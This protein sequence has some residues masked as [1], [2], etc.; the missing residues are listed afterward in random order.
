[1]KKSSGQRISG[2]SGE[3]VIVSRKSNAMKMEVQQAM[4]KRKVEEMAEFCRNEGVGNEY[5][6]LTM[7]T[8]FA[9]SKK[10]G[11][12]PQKLHGELMRMADEKVLCKVFLAQLNTVLASEGVKSTPTGVGIDILRLHVPAVDEKQCNSVLEHVTGFLCRLM[13]EVPRVS[14]VSSVGAGFMCTFYIVSTAYAHSAVTS[15]LRRLYRMKMHM[16]ESGAGTAETVDSETADAE[17]YEL[18]RVMCGIS[19]A[20]DNM[21]FEE[22]V[23]YPTMPGVVPC[24]VVVANEVR[25]QVYTPSAIEGIVSIC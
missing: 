22:R 13:D 10:H 9:F 8:P 21:F 6:L 17:R 7:I 12:L 16:F 1:M 19:T 5:L 24:A 11:V 18:L 15:V 14:V 25:F 3:A 2:D 4:I 20:Y 23:S